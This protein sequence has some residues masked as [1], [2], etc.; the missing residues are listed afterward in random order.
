MPRI[1]SRLDVALISGPVIFAIE[2]KVG[3]SGYR[4]ADI[5]IVP[6]LVATEAT[7]SD[8]ALLVPHADGVYPPCRCNADGLAHLITEGL[9]HATGRSHDGTDWVTRR[10]P[11]LRNPGADQPA[12]AATGREQP[13][14]LADSAAV[15]QPQIAGAGLAVRARPR[16][17]D[18][19]WRCRR[20]STG[21]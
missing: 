16:R 19:R 4:R 8:T 3:E 17:C 9:A 14:P 20:A 21:S 2:F 15:A 6:I 7:W 12:W 18:G 11:V 1:G 13:T 10:H 5:P